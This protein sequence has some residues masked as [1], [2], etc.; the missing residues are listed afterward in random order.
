[1]KRAA[2]SNHADDGPDFWA[3]HPKLAMLERV[4][5]R[6]E[7]TERHFYRSP[8]PPPGLALRT[9][10]LR[11]LLCRPFQH[12][13]PAGIAV[14]ASWRDS[15]TNETVYRL[16]RVLSG[17]RTRDLMFFDDRSI[18]R[19]CSIAPLMVPFIT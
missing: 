13:D 5:R 11:G 10:S 19:R 3:Q 16:A 7:A 17:G 9:E 12:T 18:R 4:K 15:A 14:Y 6:Q 2:A 1:M 8:E